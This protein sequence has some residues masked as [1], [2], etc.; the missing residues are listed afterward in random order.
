MTLPRLIFQK[1]RNEKK[2]DRK[3]TR[4]NSSH[5]CISYAVFCLK[6]KKCH[7][8]KFSLGFLTTR[9][10]TDKCHSGCGSPQNRRGIGTARHCSGKPD[11]VVVF[12]FF[13]GSAA[14]EIFPF[15][16]GRPFFV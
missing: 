15:P 2:K 11:F 6:K 13:N 14:R 12:F 3:S 1:A 9:K 4:L 5:R 10:G 8:L 7:G 16:Q